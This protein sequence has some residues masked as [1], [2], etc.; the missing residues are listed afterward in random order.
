MPA[1][2]ITLLKINAALLL[3]CAGYYLILRH[4]TFYTI[5]RVYLFAA[6]LF[7]SIYPEIDLTGFA[8]KHQDIAE[9]VRSIIYTIQMPVG[10]KIITSPDYWLWAKVV[11]WAGVALL[12]LRLILQM[13]SLLSIYRNSSP[14]RIGR[15]NVRITEADTGPFSFW[16]TIFINPEKHSHADLTPIL[17]H[18]QIHVDELHTVDILLAEISTIF[19][20]FNPGIWL[21]KKAIR[22][23]IEFITDR[24]I[25]SKGMDSKQ[26]QYSLV[27]V[28]FAT[29]YQG[30]VNHFNISTIK[31]R[32][33]M[34]N[35][36]RSSKINLTRYVLLV[37][38]VVVLLLVFSVSKADYLKRNI[39]MI[40]ISV[41]KANPFKQAEISPT[42]NTGNVAA[43]NQTIKK[44]PASPEKR[45]ID[46]KAAKDTIKN[47]PVYIRS[48]DSLRYVIN[49]KKATKAD[50][51]ALNPDDISNIEILPSKLASKVIDYPSDKTSVLFLTTRNSEDGQKFQSKLDEIKQVNRIENVRLANNDSTHKVVGFNSI[52][53]S[54]PGT[55]N[56]ITSAKSYSKAPVN[57]KKAT[58]LQFTASPTVFVTS[59]DSSN[60]AEALTL[61]KIPASNVKRVYVVNGNTVRTKP[62]KVDKI[63]INGVDF[64]NDTMIDHLGDNV[65][66]IDGKEA[67]ERELK[68]LPVSEVESITVKTGTDVT[69][70][71]GDKAKNGIVIITTKKAKKE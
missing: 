29:N 53:V 8:L 57:G 38:A 36:K 37:P 50:F 60:V 62:V 64:D 4:L 19:Y 46:V 56:T 2:F 24:K 7:A 3:F 16:K 48:S 13:R 71:Y 14:T 35:S 52:T 23:N 40:K 55:V 9:P 21:M 49:G 66:I 61:T 47:D 1:L 69:E 54:S 15:F 65:V 12:G 25:L 18:E 51:K 5:N 42:K 45:T 11:F 63:R 31:K 27:N 20:W 67:T 22:E 28:S 43:V 33:I 58:V 10:T 30:L 41:L 32:I 70:K 44:T 17:M 34:M 39:R 6:I 68:K 59:S 26:Y